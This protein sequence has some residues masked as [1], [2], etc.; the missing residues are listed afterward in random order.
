MNNVLL[1]TLLGERINE[2]VTLGEAFEIYH[3]MDLIATWELAERAIS[4]KADV[5]QCPKNTPGIDLV[6]GVQIKYAQTNRVTQSKKGSLYGYISVRDHT[7]TILAV[8]TETV[9]GK[10]YFFR[11]PHSS[12]RHVNGNT[13]A[14]PFDI[15]GNPRRK[16]DWWYYEVDSFDKLCEMAKNA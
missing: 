4:K 13:F 11:F 1:E 10:Q 5:A 12:Y 16:S 8:V 14:V 9:T 15:D 6:S 3:S 2:V 7:E